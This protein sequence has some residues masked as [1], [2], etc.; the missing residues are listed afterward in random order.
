MGVGKVQNSS[1]ASSSQMQVDVSAGD[2]STLQVANDAVLAALSRV[3]GLAE[4]KTNLVTSKPQYQLVPTDRLAASGLNIQTLA[5]L[6]AQAING[7]LAAQA[8][9]SP[10]TIAGRVQ[11]PPGTADTAATLSLLPIPTALG[12]LPLS[13]LASLNPV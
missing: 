3:Q 8:V 4:L 13:T 1:N 6:V 10:R 7:Q 12:V 5:A 11:L 9:L 2:R